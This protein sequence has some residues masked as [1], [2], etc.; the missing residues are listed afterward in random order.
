VCR[1]ILWWKRDPNTCFRCSWVRSESFHFLK[2]PLRHKPSISSVADS[3]QN[4]ASRG[5]LIADLWCLGSGSRM[6]MSSSPSAEVPQ[7]ARVVEPKVQQ[8]ANVQRAVAVRL[9]DWELNDLSLPPSLVGFYD[10]T[11]KVWVPI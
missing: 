6:S 4:G 8:A 1:L 10:L 2:Q 7:R 11:V 9:A 5:C 3:F